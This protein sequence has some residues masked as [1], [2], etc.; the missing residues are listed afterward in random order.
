MRLLPVA[1]AVSVVLAG[2]APAI[3]SD[4][5]PTPVPGPTLSPEAPARLGAAQP[6]TI[7]GTDG[8]DVLLGTP[9][10][11]VICGNDGNDVLQGLDG[12]DVLDG[13]DGAD[14]ASFDAALC[15]I[16]AD[17]A[18]RTATGAGTDQLIGIEHLTG[19]QGDDVLRGDAG[20][21][22]LSGLGGVDLLHG[23][24]GDDSLLG[25]DGDDWLAGEGGANALDGGEGAD[26][27]AEGVGNS[28]SP[29]SPTD[30]D[31]SRGILDVRLVAT[32]LGVSPST[33][34]IATFGKASKRR[35]W[36][37]GYFV[38]SFDTQGDAA[39]DLQV[40][41]RSTGRRIRAYLLRAGMRRPAGQVQAGHPGARSVQVRVPLE[42]LVIPPER[43]YYRW[44]VRTILTARGCR[45]CFDVVPSEG[46][47]AFPQPV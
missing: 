46:E 26:V 22:T 47:G 38:V 13:G 42:G 6:C 5:S 34:R 28:C 24:D 35:L 33:W 36:D 3:A 21:N 17:L 7:E 41:A 8:D 23:G 16:R 1:L 14:T 11:D 2:L 44:S 37:E 32:A 39:F 15:C 25:G 4:P 43:A 19:S 40:V 10:P 20:A 29:P 45:P 31:D 9:G 18:A 27:C 30:P 12:D